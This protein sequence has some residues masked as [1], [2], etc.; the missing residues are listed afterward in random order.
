MRQWRSQVA[1]KVTHAHSP[2]L[3]SPCAGLL[4]SGA[5]GKGDPDRESRRGGPVGGVR[6]SPSLGMRR[7]AQSSRHPRRRRSRRSVE[8]GRVP[9]AER[10]SIWVTA[11][12]VRPPGEPSARARLK[13]YGSGQRRLTASS[14]A[15]TLATLSRIVDTWSGGA[16]A[17]GG[18]LAKPQ[19]STG[20][21]F[22][23]WAVAP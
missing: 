10:G 17:V 22:R 16:C 8:V 9:A 13:K 14:R 21:G 12:S 18:D 3:S 1:R 15:A 6:A 5:A 19:H 2:P 11:L 23:W 4:L 7:R 20:I